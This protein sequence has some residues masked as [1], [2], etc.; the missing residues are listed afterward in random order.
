[1]AKIYEPPPKEVRRWKRFVA[2]MPEPVRKVAERF[3]PWTL[4]QI[5]STGDRVLIFSFCEDDP[6]TVTVLILAQFN[7][8]LFERR[9]FGVDPDDL[10]ECDLPAE[11]EV[12]GAMMTHDE[13]EQNIDELRVMVRPDLWTM[14]PDGIARRKVN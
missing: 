2:T 5:K 11:G 10:A 7:A 8:V 13:V 4:Y 9:V 1:M 3:N 14:G 12:L 6:V